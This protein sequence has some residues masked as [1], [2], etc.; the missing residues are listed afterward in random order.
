MIAVACDVKLDLSMRIESR[1][2]HAEVAFAAQ[3]SVGAAKPCSVDSPNLTVAVKAVNTLSKDNP[4]AA[5]KHLSRRAGLGR[6]ALDVAKNLLR[7]KVPKCVISSPKTGSSEPGF[8]RDRSRS[9]RG[10]H[11]RRG[12]R[13]EAGFIHADREPR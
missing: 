12:L 4:S 11:D 10:I 1:G 9:R 13:R 3:V 5:D 8:R 7:W 2:D 6:K